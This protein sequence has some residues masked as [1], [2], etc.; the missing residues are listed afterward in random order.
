VGRCV[1]IWIL[2]YSRTAPTTDHR[3]LHRAGDT[4]TPCA[5]QR[6]ASKVT[7]PAKAAPQSGEVVFEVGGKLAEDA[8]GL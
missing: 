2:E 4:T 8:L 7:L 1:G 6:A 5:G 3:L